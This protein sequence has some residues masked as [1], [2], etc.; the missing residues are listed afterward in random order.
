MC[1]PAI[2]AAIGAAFGGGAA[3]TAAGATAA[4]ATTA[5]AGWS[6][7]SVLQIAGLATSVVGSVQQASAARETAKANAAY[8]DQQRRDQAQI[9]G[10]E[11]MRT[12]QQFRRAMGQ[13][14]AELAKRGIQLDSPTALLLGQT[15]AREMAFAS[16]SVRSGAQARDQELSVERQNLLA[17]GQSDWLR[18]TLSG[19]G[20]L[21]TGAPDIWPELAG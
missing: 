6:L 12:R 10:V 17:R 1:L 8:I 11:D 13:Q 7:G 18:G 21:L 15:A 14:T 4:A 3:A 20:R 9:A 16:E 19:V 2:G 5:S